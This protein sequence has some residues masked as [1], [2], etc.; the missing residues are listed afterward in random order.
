MLPSVM[1]LSNYNASRVKGMLLMQDG[2]VHVKQLNLFII[3]L[4]ASLD[5][6]FF[7]P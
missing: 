3:N 7:V 2:D 6:L 4:Q 5:H 1:V